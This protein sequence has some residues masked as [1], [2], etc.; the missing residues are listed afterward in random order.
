MAVIKGIFATKFQ[1]R[2][3]N[4]VFRNVDGKNIASERPANVKNPRTL[5]QQEQRMRMATIMAAYSSM[6]GICDHS[7][8]GLT[9]GA[10]NMAEFM[11]LNLKMANDWAE[12][13]NIK[14]NSS[15]VANPY[16][17]SKGSL[18]ALDAVSVS[19]NTIALVATSAEIATIKVAEFFALFGLNVGDQLTIL[20]MIPTKGSVSYG[21]YTQ[22]FNAVH[23]RRI[24]ALTGTDDQLM[25]TDGALNADVLEDTSITSG[26]SF[27]VESG[28]LVATFDDV[29]SVVAGAIIGSSKSGGKWLRTTSFMV[30][31]GDAVKYPG[32]D[33]VESYSVSGDYYLN[34]GEAVAGNIVEGDDDSSTSGGGGTAGGGGGTPGGNDNSGEE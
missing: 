4:V 25:F 22:Q 26:M 8:E 14:G 7:F 9:Y 28:N 18:G 32:A 27:S 15:V 20:A 31:N 3:G 17:V 23:Y 5:A 13:F 24:I 34:N 19:D 6:K 30:V 12:N 29:T 11:K 21:T 33:V 1:G 16:Q 10:K 2:V